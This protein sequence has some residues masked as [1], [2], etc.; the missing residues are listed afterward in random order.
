MT[1][2][3]A[4]ELAGPPRGKGR[5]RA[6]IQKAK[7]SGRLYVQEYPDG[8]TVKY[9]TQLRYVGQQRMDGRPPTILPLRVQVEVTL[10]IAASGPEWERAAKLAGA[11]VPIS[12]GTGDVDNYLKILDALN[13]IVWADDSQIVEARVFKR[14][15]N[16]PRLAILVE[17]LELPT[18]E[19]PERKRKAAEPA[20]PDLFATL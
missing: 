18:V 10:Q 5:H 20:A 14:Y 9:E 4:I 3:L 19:K 7:G 15:G 6:R 12:K 13:G 17:A 11:I 2:R 16:N 8:E 1:F